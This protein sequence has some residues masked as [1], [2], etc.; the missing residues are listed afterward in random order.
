[1]MLRAE[2]PAG[3]KAGRAPQDCGGP[4]SVPGRDTD[5]GGPEAVPGG[6]ADRRGPEAVPRGDAD[7]GGPI[8]SLE[9]GNM[10]LTEQT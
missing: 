4:E 10:R 9:A 7:R 1:M 2:G 8:L 5:R 3:T 6:D